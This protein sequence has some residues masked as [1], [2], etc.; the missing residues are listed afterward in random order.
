MSRPCFSSSP[1]QKNLFYFH[2]SSYLLLHFSGP[3]LPSERRG[4]LDFGGE[5][6]PEPP[7]QLLHVGRFGPG[8][9]EA[10][11]PLLPVPSTE[12]PDHLEVL[13]CKMSNLNLR[14]IFYQCG[15]IKQTIKPSNSGFFFIY[16][17]YL[18]LDQVKLVV[19]ITVDCFVLLY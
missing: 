7:L 10:A 1:S 6:L 5:D 3:V 18:S 13:K 19:N 17:N 9:V 14:F 11:S 15:F 8:Q 12:R 16:N 4:R 2:G